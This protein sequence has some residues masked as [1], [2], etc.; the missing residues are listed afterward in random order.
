MFTPFIMGVKPEIGEI[1]HFI[2]ILANNDN[3][4]SLKNDFLGPARRK[5]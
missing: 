1:I 2:A 5:I 4:Y 3:G